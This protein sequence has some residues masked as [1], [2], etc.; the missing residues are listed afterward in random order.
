MK[1]K[2][3]H[4]TIILGVL[5]V[6]FS[7]LVDAIGLGKSGIQ[8]A[9]ILGI[10]AGVIIVLC[11]VALIILQ[12]KREP[13]P[14]P[15]WLNLRDKI[16]NLPTLFW[17]ALGVLPA[18]IPLL[19]IP[20]FFNSGHGIYYPVEYLQNINPIGNDFR[21]LLNSAS[22]WL[23]NHQTTQHI[24]T[25]LTIFLFSPLLLLGYPNAYYVVATAT[26]ISYLILAVLAF[27]MTE[28]GKHLV[29][30]FIATISLFSY[31]LQFELERGQSHTIALMLCVLA[32][33]IFH[34]Q[35]HFRLFAYLLFCISVQI[36]FYP[37]LFIVMFVDD[38]R[39]WKNILIRFGAIGVVNF[40]ALF[41]LGSS[42]FSAFYNHTTNGLAETVELMVGNHSIQSFVFVLPEVGVNLL[43][44]DAMTWVKGN[45]DFISTTLY[46]F[47]L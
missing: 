24:F 16:Y 37:G 34:K 4:L 3:S 2:F 21:I 41:L 5:I 12:N 33:Y 31:G 20:M 15:F 32:V 47:F 6:L 10:Q 9:Q 29:I 13:S 14:L 26:L 36:K 35:P 38:W 46:A 40:L 28:K 22:N 45:A 19:I 43:S 11:G 1:N 25:P 30:V 27:A 7:L 23:L 8:A 44:R 18:F 39:D 17:V 42:Y